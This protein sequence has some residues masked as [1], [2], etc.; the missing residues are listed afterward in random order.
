MA[1][2]LL[3]PY[4]T[5]ESGVS[6]PPVASAHAPHSQPHTSPPAAAI[7]YDTMTG[8]RLPQR[9]RQRVPGGSLVSVTLHPTSNPLHAVT[10]TAFF[11][12]EQMSS[13]SSP[14]GVLEDDGEEDEVGGDHA[15]SLSSSASTGPPSVLGPSLDAFCVLLDDDADM[16]LP[17][18]DI[19]TLEAGG[20]LVVSANDESHPRLMLRARPSS[21]S[22]AFTAGD[23]GGGLSSSSQDEGNAMSDS[24]SEQV[25]KQKRAL[26]QCL[27][28]V[29]LKATEMGARSVALFLPT[30][31]L[32]VGMLLPSDIQRVAVQVAVKAACKPD[33]RQPLL[34][35]IT[36]CLDEEPNSNVVRGGGGQTA[37]TSTD[38]LAMELARNVAEVAASSQLAGR[39]TGYQARLV[40]QAVP[41]SQLTFPVSGV[42]GEGEGAAGSQETKGDPD[43]HLFPQGPGRG[44]GFFQQQQSQPQDTDDSCSLFSRGGTTQKEEETK[45]ERECEVAVVTEDPA[46]QEAHLQSLLAACKRKADQE[47][48]LA[49]MLVKNQQ[50][51]VEPPPSEE[52]E[53]GGAGPAT[54]TSL[55]LSR[56]G[57]RAL[58][59]TEVKHDITPPSKASV[60]DGGGGGGGVHAA[61]SA[62]GVKRRAPPQ[63]P[64]T[65][66]AAEKEKSHFL[67]RGLPAR[68]ANC[69]N[70]LRCLALAPSSL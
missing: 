61:L 52:R 29:V 11:E 56:I 31:N 39:T 36:L 63:S 13:H 25:A 2:T 68:V 5:S 27:H 15:L 53:K 37:S 21:A 64:L 59:A 18:S 7:I 8:E 4:T 34:S 44:M 47:F 66:A 43:P 32:N 20:V 16:G 55:A 65:A 38:A 41:L 40:E 19:A 42:F 45:E 48:A 24:D 33:G 62:I 35:D 58:A 22:A 46:A 10:I 26:G 60:T 3:P 6:A 14:G 57:L 50:K 12:K 28:Q 23:G 70:E 49:T 51:A 17:S 67:I 1:R 69:L 30:Y 9:Q 54:V